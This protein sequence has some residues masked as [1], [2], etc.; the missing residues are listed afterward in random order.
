MDFGVGTAT[1]S[2]M[3]KEQYPEVSIIGVDID[4]KILEI[5]R[6]KADNKI[7]LLN[8]D[9]KSI[10]FGNNYFD[11][12]VSSLVFHH[13][14]TQHKSILLN[15]LLRVVKPEGKLIIA[16][17]GKPAN[18]YTKLAFAIFRR[19]DGEENTRINAKGLLPKIISTAGFINVQQTAYF[20]TAFGTVVLLKATKT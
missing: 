1:L 15:E 13:I 12:I 8:Y 5:A 20:N 7:T 6:K 16:D 14:P 18:W 2:L 9:G 17:F 4:N 11:K 19:F 3:I 10:P